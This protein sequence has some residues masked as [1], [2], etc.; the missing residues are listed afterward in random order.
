MFS[1]KLQVFV[2]QNKFLSFVILF[3]IASIFIGAYRYYSPFPVGDMWQGYLEF[4][5][6]LLDGDYSAWWSQH[7]EHRI[8]VSKLFFYLDLK[9]FGGLSL[10]LIPLNLILLLMCWGGLLFYSV[11]L[12]KDKVSVQDL[13]YFIAL[14]IVFSFSWKQDENIVWA[15]Q[16]QFWLAYLFPLLAFLF[17][18]LSESHQDRGKLYY[19]LSCIFGI[20]SA[21]TMANGVLVL[22]ILVV[23]SYFLRKTWFSISFLVAIAIVS[24]YLYLDSYQTAAHNHSALDNIKNLKMEMIIFFI[25]YL[26]SPL[27]SMYGSFVFG[28]LHLYLICNV[29]IN[30]F[31]EKIK[32]IYFSIIAFVTYYLCSAI[33]ITAARVDIGISAAL[34]GR[35]TTPTIISFFLVLILFF[36][37]SP[38]NIRYINKRN[39]TIIAVLMLGTQARTIIKNVDKIHDNQRVEAMQLELGVYPKLEVQKIATAAASRNMSI[40]NL[41]PF[42]DQKEKMNSKIDASKCRIEK[43][44]AISEA[45]YESSNLLDKKENI[46]G[47]NSNMEIIGIGVQSRLNENRINLITQNNRNGDKKLTFYMC[48]G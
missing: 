23:Q 11:H 44:T 25:E 33:I 6:S 3:Y 46:Y 9:Y 35:Y 27:K 17:L 4:Y 26:G 12:L 15:F 38:R 29:L 14:L 20:L 28:I 2:K 5:L 39:V 8:V 21:G 7:N 41:R 40:F 19:G 13:L 22:P 37:F 31:K 32:P 10:L 36:H 16:S 24:T 1:N 34:V 30:C 43:F 45:Q 18:S 48:S 47:V 42:V